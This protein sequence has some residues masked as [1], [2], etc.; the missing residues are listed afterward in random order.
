MSRTDCVLLVALQSTDHTGVP[1]SVSSCSACCSGAHDQWF[2]LHTDMN[3][4]LFPGESWSGRAFTKLRWEKPLCS[5]CKLDNLRREAD[6][7]CCSESAAHVLWLLCG[8]AWLCALPCDWTLLFC[9]YRNK[10]SICAA[11][12]S[13]SLSNECNIQDK[14]ASWK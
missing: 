1:G 8:S 5:C 2:N 14:V 10:V 6:V 12:W 7:D 4:A 13:G 11:Y 3:C 9:L